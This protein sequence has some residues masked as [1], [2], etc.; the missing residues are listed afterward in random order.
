MKYQG[1]ELD[2]FDKASNMEK[3]YIFKYK[4]LY[5]RPHIRSG[6]WNWKFHQQL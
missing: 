2:N 6:S 3:I 5:K 1:Q 4:K